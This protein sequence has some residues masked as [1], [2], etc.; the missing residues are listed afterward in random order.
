MRLIR[1]GET[2]SESGKSPWIWFES[3]VGFGSVVSKRNQGMRFEI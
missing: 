2:E 1:E 3:V